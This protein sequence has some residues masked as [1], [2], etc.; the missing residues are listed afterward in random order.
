M[1][2]F[3][4][5]F[6]MFLRSPLLAW[7][8]IPGLA[9]GLTAVVLLISYLTY[10]FSF[11][12][13]FTT[14]DRVLRVH[15]RLVE[16]NQTSVLPISLYNTKDMVLSNVPG[17]ETGTQ[18]YRGWN[19]DVKVD[20]TTFRRLE[21]LYAD[22]GFFHVFGL[23]LI[24]GDK[25]NALMNKDN[26]VLTKSTAEKLFGSIDCIG[27]QI[28]YNGIRAYVSGVMNDLP[29]ATH[30][31]F[32]MLASLKIVEPENFGGLEFFTYF[33]LSEHVSQEQAAKGIVAQNNKA[34]EPWREG[35]SVTAETE[36]EK[37][38]H[39]HM[40]SNVTFDLSP[41][42]NMTY[43]YTVAAIAIPVFF[44]A[45]VNFLNL[46]VLHG[47]RRISEIA[48]RKSYGA[49]T[50]WLFRL[51]GTD[52]LV[53]GGIMTALALLIIVVVHPYFASVMQTDITL[54]DL[55]SAKSLLISG[56]LIVLLSFIIATYPTFYL[57]RIQLLNGLKGIS[58]KIHRRSRMSEIS[59]L[60]Q[61]S[62]A[63]FLL[64]SML[65]MNAQ[66]RFLKNIPL[67]FDG[68]NVLNVYGITEPMKSNIQAVKNELQ[69]LAFVEH[70]A[71]SFHTMGHGCSGQLA[72]IFGSTDDYKSMN[73]YRV[74][75]GFE[76]T[77]GLRLKQGRFFTEK[78]FDRMGVVFNETAARMLGITEVDGTMLDLGF[79]TAMPLIGIVHDFYYS[80][81]AGEEIE[82]LALTSYDNSVRNIYLRANDEFTTDQKVQ[83]AQV[84]QQFDDSY[85]YMG[86][87]MGQ[88]Y[89]GKYVSVERTKNLVLGGA[90]LAIILCISGL[91]ALSVM[92][93]NRRTKEVGI[94]KVLGCSELQVVLSLMKQTLKWI[95][96]SA[97]IAF[98]AMYSY[99]SDWLSAFKNKIEIDAEFYLAS[100]LIVFAL[101]CLAIVWQ[102]WRAA[103]A[104]P[105]NSL[106]YE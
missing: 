26:V 20:Q 28:D 69:K 3:R 29:T 96:L 90:A 84:L 75:P 105:V 82:P 93:V 1:A 63:I 15:N 4:F 104:N 66:I 100:A 52:A 35:F 23:E 87:E 103:T 85:A 7:G 79:D 97:G 9:V 67:G 70:V 34:M 50:S 57:S 80:G 18:L 12:R 11:D 81:D 56:L 13:H 92:N 98:V 73:E 68:Q 106:K 95:P 71:T 45:L 61:F 24:H 10:E 54:S 74:Q 47:E 25:N 60:L 94:R 38:S 76:N 37:L 72:K 32:D 27:Q 46:Y 51:F 64:S 102:T 44:I 58:D 59:L 78:E 55:L 19:T 21:L 39:I 5:S 53:M 91:V 99:M 65:V 17:I 42:V 77:L 14:K 101:A 31:D 30:F 16:N 6:R 41:K 2:H 86:R 43:I 89:D 88:L 8:G 83:I 40:F 62:V 49:T 33:L 22:E 36:V 48:T